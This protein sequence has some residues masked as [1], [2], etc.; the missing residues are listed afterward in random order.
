MCWSWPGCLAAGRKRGEGGAGLLCHR[1]C[2]AIN[3][4]L[5]T[6]DTSGAEMPKPAYLWAAC[7]PCATGAH[8]RPCLPARW[9]ATANAVQLHCTWSRWWA[10]LDIINTVVFPH[11]VLCRWVGVLAS[12]LLRPVPALAR[13]HAEYKQQWGWHS[14]IAGVHIRRTDKVT[15]KEA[16]AFEVH[17]YMQQVDKWCDHH[18]KAGWRV[19]A[20]AGIAEQ[21]ASP[22]GLGTTLAPK[23]TFETKAAHL[24]QAQSQM[25]QSAAVT[26]SIYLAT[27]EP[28]VVA[29]VKAGYPHIQVIINPD[30][31]ATGK[32]SC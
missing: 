2:S 24:H 6:Q 3:P 8:Q 28:S 10:L 7:I 16:R 12:F 5:A 23:S 22:D 19:Q 20:R 27:D 13:A 9:V 25:P 29:N 31:V 32:R 26:C 15:K 4:L 17:Q 21:H 14:P 18:F 11:H 1:V 30:G